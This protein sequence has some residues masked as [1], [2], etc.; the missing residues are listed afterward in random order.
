MKKPIKAQNIVKSSYIKILTYS[1][2]GSGKTSLCATLGNAFVID[3]EN[4]TLSI[5]GS[6]CDIWDARSIQDV[7]DGYRYFCD[8]IKD[9]SALCI[10]SIT[11]LTEFMLIQE[12][13]KVGKSFDR[14]SNMADQIKAFVEE[15]IDS[16][17]HV[18]VTAIEGRDKGNDKGDGNW[19]PNTEGKVLPEWLPRQFDEVFSIVDCEDEDGNPIRMLQTR[20]LKDWVLKDRSGMLDVY[21]PCDLKYIIDKIHGD[22]PKENQ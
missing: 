5:A 1:K 11:K 19:L 7:W 4:G 16:P 6:D 9:Y 14:Y 21:E 18:Y 15:L 3:I 8:H 12:T 10:D 2:S 22:L 20:D 13:Q 17:F